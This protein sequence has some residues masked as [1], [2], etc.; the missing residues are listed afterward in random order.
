M[1]KNIACPLLR[2]SLPTIVENLAAPNALPSGKLPA[3]FLHRLLAQYVSSEAGVELGAGVGRDAAVIACS[4]R[5]LIAKTDPI[6]FVTENIGHYVV[7]VNANDIACMGG[8]PKWFMATLLFPDHKTEE[9]QV[10]EIFRQISRACA[11]HAIA[12]CGGHTEITA[13]VTQPLVIGMMFGEAPRSRRYAPARIEPGD[14]ILLT[15]GLA[16]EATAIIGKHKAAALAEIFATDFASHCQ[17]FLFEPGISV[18]AAAKLAWEV[19]G[20]HALHDPTE[21]GLANAVHELLEEKKLGVEIYGAQV[22]LLPETK[23]LCEHFA[24]DPLGLIASGALLV[25]G[26][27]GA[28]EEL[29]Q[30]YHAAN[31]PAAMI[32]RV[33]DEGEE[34]WLLEDNEKQALPRFSRDEIL[35]VLD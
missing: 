24:L 25:V 14:H 4:D 7:Q 2:M 30:K 20:I 12:W 29:L 1:G 10:E 31:I 28:C 27:A 9:A 18:L 5:L 32:G 35:R 16:V 13:T 11:T 23:L 6:T 26:Q 34:R 8:E 19:A 3:A 22:L 17:N 33:L 15:K 21:G